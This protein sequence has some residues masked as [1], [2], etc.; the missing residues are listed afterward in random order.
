VPLAV[1]EDTF[2]T[3]SMPSRAALDGSSQI[4]P[5]GPNAK[6]QIPEPS[7]VGQPVDRSGKDT[8]NSEISTSGPKTPPYF[9]EPI[10]IN[11]LYLPSPR[12]G[13]ANCT[14]ETSYGFAYV[15]VI[16]RPGFL[17]KPFAFLPGTIIV[18]ERLPALHASPERLVVMVKHERDFNP[19]ANGW[20]FLTVSGDGSKILKRDQNGPCLKCH[21]TTSDN[22]FVFPED[23]RFR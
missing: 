21:A 11:Q 17:R 18:R 22:D 10:T 3:Y 1:S 12:S 7:A 9:P 20:E 8:L 15:N 5:T 16:G 6:V 23:G 14:H 2:D 13:T 4:A 19:K